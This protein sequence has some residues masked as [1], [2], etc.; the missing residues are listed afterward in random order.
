MDKKVYVILGVSAFFAVV[1]LCSY[2]IALI[3]ILLK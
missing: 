2:T 1:A 3:G